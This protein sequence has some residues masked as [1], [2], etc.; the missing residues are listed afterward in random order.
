MWFRG[1]TG[2]C[3]VLLVEQE[4]ESQK[5]RDKKKWAMKVIRKAPQG[6]KHAMTLMEKTTLLLR[7]MNFT[8]S[9]NGEIIK[10]LQLSF[11]VCLSF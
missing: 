5:E 9:S 4:R 3:G 10:I 2:G 8:G 1:R 11:S 7:L 6:E